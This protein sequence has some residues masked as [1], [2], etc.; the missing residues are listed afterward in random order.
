LDF[1]G[2]NEH[3]VD[4]KGRAFVPSKFLESMEGREPR[5]LYVTRGL[6][7]CLALYPETIWK[8]KVEKIAA[9]PD[10]DPDKRAYMRVIAGSAKKQEIDASGRLLIPEEMRK[11]A[12]INEKVV[13]V[14]QGTYIELWD[15]E[16]WFE[17]Y[18]DVS[19]VDLEAMAKRLLGS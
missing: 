18:G 1:F 19:D 2:T 11:R 7:G 8:A 12:A 5:W 16:R 13:F 9:K 17:K 14:G 3:S 4:A 15:R 10:G 6:E